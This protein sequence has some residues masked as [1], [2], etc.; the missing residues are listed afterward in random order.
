MCSQQGK[1]RRLMTTAGKAENMF[2]LDILHHHPVHVIVTIGFRQDGCPFFSICTIG[3]NIQIK[4]GLCV[5]AAVAHILTNQLKFPSRYFI[6]DIH[7]QHLTVI[8]G[9]RDFMHYFTSA[10]SYIILSGAA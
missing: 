5:V 3:F 8:E 2:S 4:E 7:L 6:F 1:N 10:P 9:D